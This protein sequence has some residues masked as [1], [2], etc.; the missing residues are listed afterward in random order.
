MAKQGTV[1][2]FKAGGKLQINESD[3]KKFLSMG[4]ALKTEPKADP[5]KAEPQKAEPAKDEPKK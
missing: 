4:Y 1:Q 5:P 2:V 3:L